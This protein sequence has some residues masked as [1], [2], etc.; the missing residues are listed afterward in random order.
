MLYWE[1]FENSLRRQSLGKIKHKYRLSTPTTIMS[2]KGKAMCFYCKKVVRR[3]RLRAHILTVHG[4]KTKYREYVSGSSLDGFLQKPSSLG[5]GFGHP[6]TVP[7]AKELPTSSK[8]CEFSEKKQSLQQEDPQ[9]IGKD[10]DIDATE[11]EESDQSESLT[12][13]VPAPPQSPDPENEKVSPHFVMGII[14]LCS[15]RMWPTRPPQLC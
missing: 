2:S 7:P 6:H 5:V 4:L 14:F 15:T 11:I 1:F 10:V 13:A 8:R 12:Q 9:Q 3:D